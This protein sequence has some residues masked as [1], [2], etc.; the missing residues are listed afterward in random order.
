MPVSHLHR[1]LV[2]G[3]HDILKV[4]LDTPA[5]VYLLENPNYHLFMQNRDYTFH[6][7]E[8][9]SSPFMMKPPHAGAWDLVIFST[10]PGTKLTA[11]IS[12]VPE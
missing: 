9:D 1:S 11:D 2:F 12:I 6:G 10:Q 8:V 5:C 4:V 7:K 3:E